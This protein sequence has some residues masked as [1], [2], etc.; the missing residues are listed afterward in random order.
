MVTRDLESL[1]I[2]ELARLRD[3]VSEKL[4]ESLNPNWKN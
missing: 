3:S 2:E 4:A 1:N